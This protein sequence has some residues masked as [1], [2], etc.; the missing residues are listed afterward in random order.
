MKISTAV[1][2]IA[3]L[4]Y[5]AVLVYTFIISPY[6]KEESTVLAIEEEMGKEPVHVQSEVCKQCHLEVFTNLSLGNHSGVECAACHGTGKE[7]V[8][9]RT[10]GSIVV[11]DTRDACMICHKKIAGRNIP[12]VEENHGSGVRC[13]YC[14][15]PHSANV[16]S[17]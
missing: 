15:D 14:H 16:P 17:E 3:I 5:A 11:E 7:H 2:S 12:T 10:A 4:I 1:F 8:K 6:I 13:S 9:L